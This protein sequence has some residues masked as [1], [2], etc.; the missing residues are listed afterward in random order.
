MSKKLDRRTVLQGVG[1]AMALP[2]L[3]A[4]FPQQSAFAMTPE[5]AP[6]RAAFIFVP[7][8]VVVPR[9]RPQ[10]DSN[11]PLQLTP[12]LQ[13]LAKHKDQINV[14][15]GLT[16]NH[17]RA[18]G[19]GAGDHA[20]NASAFLTGAQPRKTSG[21]D[22]KVGQSIDQAAAGKVGHLTRLPSIELGVVRGRNAGSCD[23]GYSCAYSS[24]ISWKT[25]NTP[26]QKEINPKLAFERL[27]G[28]KGTAENDKLRNRTRSSI[29]D[30]VA[31]DARKLKKK[32][33]QTDRRKID[34]YFN[35]VREVEQNI[36]RAS[37]KLIEVPDYEVPD[38]IPGEFPAHAKLMF[39]IMTLAFQTDC[40]RIATFMMGNA[41]SNRSYPD[42]NVKD[43]HHQISHH[44]KDPK[45]LEKLARID[46]FLVQQFSY[47]LDRLA[48]VQE[49]SGN[50]LTNSMV[51]YGSAIADGN[52]HHHHDLPILVAGQGGGSIKTGRHLAF[53]KETPLNNLFLSLTDRL[54]AK[55]DHIGDSTGRLDIG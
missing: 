25:E 39:D 14:F 41:G 33:G 5:K 47:F 36:K 15:T 44:R 16:Q 30:L 29:L 43:G 42:V 24:N 4:M 40:T 17:A 7:N 54:G 11:G 28:K 18:N 3:E 22:I 26:S 52:R 35:S 2:M 49:G 50:L 32:L 1:T 10:G 46:K 9:W 27:F 21:A 48:S 12:S 55:L 34:E 53:K 13:P 45:K 8:G 31:D 37:E 38:G 6:T 51:L 20:R 23:S 19:D